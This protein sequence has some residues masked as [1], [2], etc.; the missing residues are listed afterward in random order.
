MKA[1]IP[2]KPTNAEKKAMRRE[3]NQQIIQA[4]AKYKRDLVALVLWALHVHPDTQYGKKRLKNFYMT[5]DKI[6]QD[7]LDYYEMC[8]D[9]AAWLCQYNLKEIGV[10]ID[11]WEKELNDKT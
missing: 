11:E 8:D 1:R 2:W 3:I 6:H 7:M 5:F 10:D 4:D 9:E